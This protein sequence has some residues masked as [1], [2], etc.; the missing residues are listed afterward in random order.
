MLIFACMKHRFLIISIKIY[1]SVIFFIA[2][3]LGGR[4]P[5]SKVIDVS[6]WKLFQVTFTFLGSDEV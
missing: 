5:I 4:E 1:S 3:T 6:D 2:R